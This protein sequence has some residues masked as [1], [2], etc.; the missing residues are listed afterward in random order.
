MKTAPHSSDRLLQT[1]DES[2]VVSTS[3]SAEFKHQ[4]RGAVGEVV[5]Q[6]RANKGRVR[7]DAL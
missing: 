6:G 1:W 2:A 7:G 5:G 4:L 3:T